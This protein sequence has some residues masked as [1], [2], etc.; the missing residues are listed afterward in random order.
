MKSMKSIKP[1]SYP[2]PSQKSNIGAEKLFDEKSVFFNK[3]TKSISVINRSKIQSKSQFRPF[4]ESSGP[5]LS[6]CTLHFY[7]FLLRKILNTDF[8]KIKPKKIPQK[9][10]LEKIRPREVTM[11]F[12]KSFFKIIRSSQNDQPEILRILSKNLKYF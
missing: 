2:S 8:N 10:I 3:K 1:L 6:A 12:R 7:K 5:A 4:S 11:F 9:T